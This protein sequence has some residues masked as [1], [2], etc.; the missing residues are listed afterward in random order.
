MFVE[1]LLKQEWGQRCV[2]TFELRIEGA[3]IELYLFDDRGALDVVVIRIELKI[4]DF[5]A[6]PLLQFNRSVYRR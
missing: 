1:V 6:M 5:N 3:V 4:E 2:D